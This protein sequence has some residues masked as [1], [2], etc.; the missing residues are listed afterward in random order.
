MT[1]LRAD[2]AI[3]GGGLAGLCAARRL[4]ALGQHDVVILE[5]R[6]RFGGRIQSMGLPN[7]PDR[8]DVGA[9]WFWPDMQ[10]EVMALVMQLGL[11]VDAQHEQGHWTFERRADLPAVQ[12]AGYA[13]SPPAMRLRGGMMALVDAL[14]AETPLA[15]QRLGHEVTA[16]SRHG[17]RVHVQAIQ[18]SGE[19]V[20]LDV[21]KVLL[22]LPPR[23]VAERV[24]FSPPLPAALHRAWQQCATWMAP[25]AKYVAVYPTPFWRDRGLSGAARSAAGPMAEI[26][27]A[28]ASQHGA[29]FG[30]LGVPAVW[31]ETVEQADMIRLCRAQLCRLFGAQAEH[32]VAEFL[33]DWARD[34]HT[35]TDADRTS[36]GEHPQRPKAESDSGEWVGRL[37]GAGSEWSR[38]H[39]GYLAGAVDAAESAVDALLRKR[40][41]P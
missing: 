40:L 29:L 15:S 39:A 30:F 27:D 25:H 8:F 21:G 16:L 3:I 37:F 22:A 12:A 28:S 32:P 6:S 26:H 20:D 41:D 14:V 17:D 35:A 11:T 2:V 1:A 18:V 24:S 31:R 7:S 36:T 9:T 38:S 13:L 33:Q 10:P 23:L 5:A 19:R 4:R 34:P